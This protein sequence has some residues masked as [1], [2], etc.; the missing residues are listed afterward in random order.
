MKLMPTYGTLYPMDKRTW[1]KFKR[2]R[3]TETNQFIYTELVANNVLYRHRVDDNNNRRHTT[4][5]IEKNWD[6]KYWPDIC[7]AWYLS[8][9]DV[10]TNYAWE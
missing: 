9:S 4:I 8:V 6:T 5:F 1:K 2:S 10:N 7:F 3:V